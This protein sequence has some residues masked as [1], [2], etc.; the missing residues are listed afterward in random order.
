MIRFFRLLTRA[1]QNRFRAA[2]GRPLGRGAEHDFCNWLEYSVPG[3]PVEWRAL[4]VFQ[5]LVILTMRA[6]Q[7]SRFRESPAAVWLHPIGFSFLVL[8]GVNAF[9][10]RLVGAGVSWKKRV[11]GDNSGVA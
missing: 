1:A 10:R 6:L 8:T 5:V 7:R 9:R 11:Y 4:F 3:F 2:T